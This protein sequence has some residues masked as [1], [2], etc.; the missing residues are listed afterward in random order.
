MELNKKILVYF[1]VL[2]CDLTPSWGQCNL[3]IELHSTTNEE[4]KSAELSIMK[5]G[6]LVAFVI[7]DKPS[8]TLKLPSFGTYNLYISH[9]THAD[10]LNEI[11]IT[12]DTTLNI[13]MV[14]QTMELNEV[15][16]TSKRSSK[17]TS[18]GEVFYLSRKAK[19]MEN[20]FRALSEI[21][22]LKVDVSNQ[23]LTMSTGEKPL[24]LVDGKLVNS[25]I[26]PIFPENIES[27]EIRDIVSAKYLEMGVTKIVNI[28]LKKN[29]SLYQYADIR[30][31]HDVPVRGGFGGTDFEF[32]SST[33]AASGSIFY[34]YLY[35]DVIHK[36]ITEQSL[37]NGRTRSGNIFNCSNSLEEELLLKWVPSDKDYVS[38]IIKNRDNGISSEGS[39]ESEYI[40]V[41]NY[42]F[43]SN[44]HSK[45]N[46][47]GVL[48]GLYQE[49]SFKDKSTFTTFLKY[50]D[51]YYDTEQEYEELI[52]DHELSKINLKTRRSQYA[53][54]FDYE[55]KEY[56]NGSFVIGNKLEYTKD[57]VRNVNLHPEIDKNVKLINNY[58]HFTYS[59]KL[60]SMYYMGSLGIQYLSTDIDKI[61]HCY[62]RPHAS[63]S[64]TWRSKNK[65]TFRLSYFLTNNLPQSSQM[66]T[67]NQSTNPWIHMEGNPLL[68]PVRKH[69]IGADYIKVWSNFR[70]QLFGKQSIYN[71][72]IESYIYKENDYQV[73]SY[74]NNG[75]FSGLSIGTS[76]NYDNNKVS[77]YASPSVSV[78]H[79]NGQHSKKS[80]E[81]N[82]SFRWDFGNFFIY[83]NII[84]KDKKYSAISQTIYKN[85]TVAHIQFAWQ[86]NKAW[87]TSIGLPYFWGTRKEE[88]RII[89]DFYSSQ[90]ISQYKSASLR[91]WILVS[92]TMRKNAKK[93]IHRKIPQL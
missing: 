47:G 35:N 58:M 83:S 72:I 19:S 77:V 63:V 21:P 46:E 38:L 18:N 89:E 25:G 13:T 78:E 28:H 40:G 45:T 9:M 12:R 81:V 87:Y 15:V 29:V 50:N 31:R 10:Y 44:E 56:T 7:L 57:N 36:A 55:S 54:T 80:V 64:L 14:E 59:G 30:T 74:R 34:N 84:W 48:Y 60:Y 24:I 79:F 20:P 32:G 3:G 43:M 52:D 5:E 73:Q 16:I 86:I 51:G 26:K 69:T 76:L 2:L 91:P 67:Y 88:M 17:I 22:L 33:F 61:Q 75:T 90:T 93:A 85:P 27:V 65:N 82:C 42:S 11:D 4:I 70:L 92:W 23:T 6:Q 68:T 71:D 39:F 41:K 1:C 49:H 53:L 66:V 8:Y 62:F 37:N